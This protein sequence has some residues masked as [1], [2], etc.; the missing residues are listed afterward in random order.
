MGKHRLTRHDLL[1][2]ALSTDS[3]VSRHLELSTERSVSRAR[4]AARGRC[5]LQAE[6]SR[7]GDSRHVL[8][9]GAESSGCIGGKIC[10][11][12]S[13]ASQRTSPQ[14]GL[15]ARFLLRRASILSLRFNALE[16]PFPISGKL[17]GEHEHPLGGWCSDVKMCDYDP[18]PGKTPHSY[19]QT[20]PDRAC[21]HPP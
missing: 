17:P 3:P 10:M 21:G 11:G 9:P 1:P 5:R 16:N 2:G 14:Q 4:R 19:G 12:Q 20:R 6:R 15:M 7:P 13:G 18:G 8:R